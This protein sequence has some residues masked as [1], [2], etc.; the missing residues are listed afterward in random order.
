MTTG[1]T[2]ERRRPVRLEAD[3]AEHF[4]AI[5]PASRRSVGDATAYLPG[6]DSR[7]TLFHPPTR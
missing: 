5:T 7:S 3:T 4:E 2:T 1:D 6:G